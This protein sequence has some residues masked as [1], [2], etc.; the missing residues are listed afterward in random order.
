[1][2]NNTYKEKPNAIQ[3]IVY[4]SLV[5]VLLIAIVM[6]YRNY[7]NRKKTY[8]VTVENAS[9]TDSFRDIALEKE[10]QKAVEKRE[11][12]RL[13]ALATPTPYPVD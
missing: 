1:M 5:F 7:M 10:Y 13:A 4:Y 3:N 9:S 2:A 12:E 6:L 8:Y 11:T